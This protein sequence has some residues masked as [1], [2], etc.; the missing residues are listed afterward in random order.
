M[1]ISDQHEAQPDRTTRP[2]PL[3]D[4]IAVRQAG[5]VVAVV[6]ALSLLL[7]LMQIVEDYFDHRAEI[8]HS[9][10]QLLAT[11]QQ[12]AAQAAFMVDKPLAR[13]VAAGLFAHDAVV[14]VQITTD[15]GETL[16]TLRRPTQE[17]SWLAELLFGDRRDFQLPLAVS[18]QA[19]AEVGSVAI[20]MDPLVLG[21]GFLVRAE[22]ALLYG[23]LRTIVMSVAIAL[24]FYRTLTRPLLTLIRSLGEVNPRRPSADAIQ[25]PEGHEHDEIGRL[26]DAA[27]SLL[28]N[29]EKNRL[30]LQTARSE[31]DKLRRRAEAASQ[32]KTR[33]LATMSHELR[34]P[35][36]AI[37]GFSE[38][39][40]D[41]ILGKVGTPQYKDY[42]KDIH[43]S[44]KHLLHLINEI[45]DISKIEAGKMELSPRPLALGQLL[46]ATVRVVE[47]RAHENHL[48]L[49]TELP[50]D[51]PMIHADE[52]AIKQVVLNL[53]SN[54]VKFTPAG[55]TITLR[56]RVTD[57]V[58]TIEVTDTGIGMSESELGRVFQPFERADNRYHLAKDANG[59]TGLG[60]ALVQRLVAMHNGHV[61]IAST[62]K[63]GTTVTIHLPLPD[64]ATTGTPPAATAKPRRRPEQNSAERT[65]AERRAA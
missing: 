11:V 37:L 57:S 16:A 29:V 17:S 63:Q 46:S 43:A 25:A 33:F 51:L 4:R 39:I 22:R 7:S 21:E 55:G 28:G 40:R 42:A 18:Q 41:E 44:G 45:L 26:V 54:A 36:N 20:T 64:A 65:A 13:E 62:P 27:N 60:L 52:Q 10:H 48:R 9:A 24:L 5:Y 31:A 59:G 34:T 23:L 8:D 6:C 30:R 49:R 61:S 32:A 38:M 14:E 56:A 19:A 35:L 3:R 58:A 53:L 50:D 1:K 2:I 15:F 47:M 12:P